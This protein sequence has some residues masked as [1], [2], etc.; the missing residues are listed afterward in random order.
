MKT[1]EIPAASLQ[2]TEICVALLML[3]TGTF[4]G[5]QE[6]YEDFVK[7]LPRVEV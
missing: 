6:L 5:L 1:S 4:K 2:T 7:Q 3:K